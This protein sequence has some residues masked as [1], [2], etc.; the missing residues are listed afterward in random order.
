MTVAY[1]KDA[2]VENFNEAYFDYN[3][4]HCGIEPQADG[5]S[6]TY[7]MWY[8]DKVKTYSDFDELATAPFFDGKTLADL[9]DSGMEFCFM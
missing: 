5:F 7:D 2:V 9:L 4:K 1:V 6:R 8:G 3:G